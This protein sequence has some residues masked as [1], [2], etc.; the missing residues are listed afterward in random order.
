MKQDGL[1]IIQ[2]K[3]VA[4]KADIGTKSH[5]GRRFLDRRRMCKIRDGSQLQKTRITVAAVEHDTATHAG[6]RAQ[7]LH[8]A[9]IVIV[10]ALVAGSVRANKQASTAGEGSTTAIPSRIACTLQNALSGSRH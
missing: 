2:A 7:E 1:K 8:A 9:L 3:G 10:G 4:N 5:P 6:P